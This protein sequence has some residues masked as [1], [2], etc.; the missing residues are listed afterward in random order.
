MPRGK[1]PQY[2]TQKNGGANLGFEQKLWQATGGNPVVS[3]D[4]ANN[5][6][7]KVLHC[8]DPNCTDAPPVGGIAEY[9][10]VEPLPAEDTHHSPGTD[11]F[12]LAGLATGGA[13]LLGTG[14]WYARRRWRAG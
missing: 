7:L 11:T 5:G 2:E 14:G 3:Y 10:Q 1:K 9:P 8:G 12:A 6:D 4:H 13:L